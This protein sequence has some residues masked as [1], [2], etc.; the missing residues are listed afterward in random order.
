MYVLR[1][2]NKQKTRLF[3]EFSYYFKTYIY[4]YVC[5]IWIFH[6]VFGDENLD[7]MK[8]LLWT[9]FRIRSKY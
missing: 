7:V 3:D 6:T 9:P 2:K 5:L 1:S 4:I 8:T